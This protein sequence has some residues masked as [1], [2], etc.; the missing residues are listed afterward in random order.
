M[1][2]ITVLTT[3]FNSEKTLEEC[4]ESILN[5]SFSDFEFILVDDGSTDNSLEI[6]ESYQDERISLIRSNHIGRAQALNLGLKNS[7]GK[8][9][10]ILDA[11][12]ESL[13]ERLSEQFFVLEN[14]NISLVAS[15]ANLV[16][17]CGDK[18]G[19]TNFPLNHD[20]LVSKLLKLEPF[21]HSSVMF[22]KEMA[23]NLGGYNKRCLKSIDFNFYLEIIQAK[24]KILC[25]EKSLINL[26]RHPGSWGVS[27][28]KSLQLFYGF[29]GLTF[30]FLTSKNK[31]NIMCKDDH[32]FL[33]FENL[34]SEWFYSS[35][36]YKNS[37]AKKYFFEARV[38]FM[39]LD[40]RSFFKS[41]LKAANM[42][43]A[44]F[45]YRGAGFDEKD[46]LSFLGYA[47][48]ESEEAR[49]IIND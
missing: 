43:P 35:K 14:E 5:Q 38:S 4:I 13:P 12:D 29:L 28:E 31:R 7:K 27:D 37:K 44:F 25:L 30:Y 41:S 34:L 49:R 15:N 47:S 45:T 39:K 18:F 48:R 23:I 17:E 9:V 16:N 42:D 24:L 20:E 19:Q 22:S 21:P 33:L 6:L 10:A 11:D 46:I 36:I 1:P 32:E 40:L 26:R 8:Y 3:F 2:K